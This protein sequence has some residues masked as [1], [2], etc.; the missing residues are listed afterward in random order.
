MNFY[1]RR[2]L[3]LVAVAMAGVLLATAT[4]SAQSQIVIFD[5]FGDADL[6]NNGIALEE[7]DVNVQGSLSD[8]TYVPGRLQGTPNEIENNEVDSVLDATDVGI[9]WLNISGFTND[10]GPGTAGTGDSSPDIRIIDDAQGAQA[11]TQSGPGGL[12][13][14]AIDDGYALAFQGRGRGN[15]AAAFFGQ[16]ISLG[17]EIGDTVTTSFDF[18]LWRDTPNAEELSPNLGNLR[19]GLYQDTDS[20]IGLENDAAGLEE[21]IGQTPEEDDIFGPTAAIFGVDEG[22]FDGSLDTSLGA[23]ANVGAL[24]DNGFFG[25]VPIGNGFPPNGSVARLNFEANIDDGVLEGDFEDIASPDDI[26][27]DPFNSEFDFVNLDPDGLYNIALS[28]ERAT[29]TVE[30]EEVPAI[31]GTVTVTDL[32]SGQVFSFGEADE[33]FVDTDSFDYFGIRGDG[34]NSSDEFDFLIDNFTVEITGSNVVVDDGLAGDF[35][36]DGVVN[37]ADFVL[38]RDGAGTSGDILADINEFAEN[39]GA[40]SPGTV[41]GSATAV[42]E[43][44]SLLLSL[45]TFV[46][47]S[48]TKRRRS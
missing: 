24:G 30:G 5:G 7:E 6:N 47:V 3:G 26:D 4:A 34:V 29:T 48:V 35:N 16:T 40:T 2:N 38:A 39:F 19:F 21:V 42:P 31:L 43:P 15:V 41:V 22:R 33:N 45:M 14:T 36:D 23:T 32:L 1:V 37:A 11:E 12:G 44:S 28:L 27:P 17:D 18:R 20:Q 9:R 8:T 10:S 25:D 46:S 13:S